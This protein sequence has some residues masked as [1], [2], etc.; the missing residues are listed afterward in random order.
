M[1]HK[2]ILEFIYKT[3]TYLYNENLIKRIAEKLYV[4]VKY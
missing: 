3:L 4:F 2:D 1:K